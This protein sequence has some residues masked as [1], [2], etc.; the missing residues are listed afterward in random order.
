[1][2]FL[3]TA[4]LFASRNPLVY[5]IIFTA[6]SAVLIPSTIYLNAEIQQAINKSKTR[7]SEDLENEQ[8]AGRA[9]QYALGVD[10]LE[11]YFLKRPMKLRLILILIGSVIGLTLA[12]Y[13]K[14]SQSRRFGVASYAVFF[15]T[16]LLSEIFIAQ[17]RCIRDGKLR[18]AK[19]NLSEFLREGNG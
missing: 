3:V 14:Q 10:A 2:T 13:W 12:V 19:T 17:W 8:L 5:G 11:T 9:K 15:G 7:L 4:L 6:Y 18:E 1:M 16:I